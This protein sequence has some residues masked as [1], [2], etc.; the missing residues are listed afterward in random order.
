MPELNFTVDS[1]LLQELGERLIGKPSIALAELVKNSYDADANVV[2]IEFAPEH[3][4][5]GEIIVRDD[6]HGMT[7]EDFRDF[8]MRIGTTH[9]V[10][11]RVSPCFGRTLTGSKG[12]GRLSVQ[13]L[14]GRLD[15]VTV[16]MPRPDFPTHWIK[17][18]VDWRK[19]ITAGDLTSATV[20]YELHGG[21]PPFEHGTE[22]RLRGL[23]QDWEADDLKDLAR[24]VW[25]LQP[26]FRKI[27]NLPD[28]E[29]FEIRFQGGTDYLR[30]FQQQLNAVMQIQTARLVG[31][32]RDGKISL[33]IEFWARGSPYETH[34]SRYDLKDLPHNNRSYDPKENLRDADL[35]IRIY[36]LEYKQPLGIRLDDLKDYMDKFAGVYVYDGGFRLPYYGQPTNDWLK[37]EYDHSQRQFLSRLLPE[38]IQEKFKHTERLRYLPTLRRVFGMVRVDTSEEENLQIAITRDRLVESKAYED[39]IGV[40]RYAFDLYAY[41]E[42]MRAYRD[43]K[44]K[45]TVVATRSIEKVEDVLQDYRERIP[46]DVYRPLKESLAEATTAVRNEQRSTLTQL[47]LL[48][49]L[50]T[51][52]IS[53]IAI[54]HE[55]RKQF[56]WL[57][58]A[59]RD[60]RT[61]A[62]DETSRS[63]MLNAIADDLS[64]WLG[65]A[66]AT[67]ALFD[68][69]SGDEIEQRER[70][71]A[72]VVVERVIEQ[73][74]FMARGVRIE[75]D[76]PTEL[77]LPQASFAEWGSHFPEC[78]LQRLQ[79]HARHA[80]PPAG[81]VI[82]YVRTRTCAPHP[83]HW[84][85]GRFE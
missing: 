84:Q 74:R 78:P 17:A 30:E 72:R 71:R 43:Q 31:Q 6:G 33:A 44:S 85:G 59:I 32:C 69:M 58:D 34:S 81:G 41:E 4:S 40:V 39:L 27:D 35:E 68:Y 26:P 16:P 29:R 21:K 47:S 64:N 65:R 14:A 79:C 24:E 60:L 23:K 1:R 70:Y 28:R 3:Q 7:L 15:V 73:T 54:Q 80:R 13:F 83:R 63:D 51:V 55:L 82:A 67:N 42:S 12:V 2:E 19:A 5:D 56:A 46:K 20:E 22:L 18:W 61:L 36:R 9:K 48:G 76:I 10:D 49:S 38:Q 62:E 57:E 8:W 77:Y 45:K 37:I 50:A 11:K 66:R 75:V 25:W 52:G 53:T